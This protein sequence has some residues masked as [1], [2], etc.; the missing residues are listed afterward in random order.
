MNVVP[1]DYQYHYEKYGLTRKEYEI[2][3]NVIQKF[4]KKLLLQNVLVMK[5]KEKLIFVEF[6][7]LKIK[8]YI[9]FYLIGHIFY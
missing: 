3:D 6:I 8:I 2:V 4:I 7:T 5:R 1:M 9:N